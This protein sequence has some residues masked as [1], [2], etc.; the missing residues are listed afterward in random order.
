MN[1]SP[2]MHAKGLSSS[3]SFYVVLSRNVCLPHL[4]LLGIVGRKMKKE[5]KEQRESD[6]SS[7]SQSKLRQP[8]S[9]R[10]QAYMTHI[11]HDYQVWHINPRPA[12]MPRNLLRIPAYITE[13][14]PLWL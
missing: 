4:P 11:E 13:T 7:G 12:L 2:R 9:P 3:S 10:P 1:V 14:E 6:S 8:N 5:K